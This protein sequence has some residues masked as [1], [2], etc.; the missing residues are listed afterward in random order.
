MYA[1]YIYYV[2]IEFK[3]IYRIVVLVCTMTAR[4]EILHTNL[5][6][7]LTWQTTELT[8]H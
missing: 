6:G 2:C 7:C 4:L 5:H 3:I 8:L 1:L